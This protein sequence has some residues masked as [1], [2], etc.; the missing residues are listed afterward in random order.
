MRREAGRPGRLRD[1]GQLGSLEGSRPAA[2]A[3]PSAARVR[4][5]A[6]PSPDDDTRGGG[7]KE[8]KHGRKRAGGA[9]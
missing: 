7:K 1:E 5:S 8:S 2:R 6:N 3:Q 4:V 9:G